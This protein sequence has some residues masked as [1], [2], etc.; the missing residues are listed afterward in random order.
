MGH[1]SIKSFSIHDLI[2][3]FVRQ[4]LFASDA[5]HAMT[6]DHGS[7]SK[8]DASPVRPGSM[9]PSGVQPALACAATLAAR[10]Q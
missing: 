5:F 9:T 3:K 8:A 6:P 10:I 4:L 7:A 1:N 2:V